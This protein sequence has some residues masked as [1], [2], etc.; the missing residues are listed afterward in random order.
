M[1]ALP[2]GCSCRPPSPRDRIELAHL[3]LDAYH[4]TIDD[5]GETITEALE[6]IDGY[7][8]RIL[9]RYSMVVELEGTLVA[10]VQE[11]RNRRR[12]GLSRPSDAGR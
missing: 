5:E 2:T 4:G 3:L 12:H 6:V 10:R 9:M 1:L 11:K 8:Q 7:L